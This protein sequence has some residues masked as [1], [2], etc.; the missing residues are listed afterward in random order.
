MLDIDFGAD[1]ASGPF[2]SWS[3]N[4]SHDGSIAPRSFSLRTRDGKEPVDF[5]KGAILDVL[6]LQTGWQRSDGLSGQAP[7]WLWN[8]A[9]SRFRAK[10]E[11]DGWKR[12][13]RLPVALG[14]DR[15]VV[16]EQAGAGAWE[17]IKRFIVQLNDLPADK[18]PVAKLKD[19]EVLKFA[20]GGTVVPILEC[21]KYVSPPACLTDDAQ[22]VAPAESKDD[23]LEF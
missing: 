11:G 8:D 19:V 4:G 16:W 18:M 1:V 2:L 7:E 20:R 15:R 21:V 12:G 17:A 3:A 14:G 13:F 9:P 5:G 10:P 22:D 23:D 6:K